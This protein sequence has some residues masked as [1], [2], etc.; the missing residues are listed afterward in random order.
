ME[1]TGQE[2]QEQEK[3][4][5]N[6]TPLQQSAAFSMPLP[7]STLLHYA[8]EARGGTGDSRNGMASLI[9]NPTPISTPAPASALGCGARSN[10]TTATATAALLPAT[11]TD[12]ALRYRQC[13]RNHA[14]SLGG[15]ILDGCCEFMPRSDDAL[16]CAACGCHRSFHRRDTDINSSLRDLQNGTHGRVPLLL[17][18]PHLSLPDHNLKLFGSAG[19]LLHTGASVGAATESSTEELMLGAV[20]QQ[21]F[22]VSKKRFRTKFTAE[23]K[24]MMMAF[25]EKVGWRMQKQHE[26]A[27]EQFCGEVGVSRQVLK[28]WMHNNKNSLRKQQQQEEEEDEEEEEEQHHHHQEEMPEA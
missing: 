25:A 11:D 28:V 6:P 8:T 26:A 9:H 23:Q 21:R 15:H 5:Y 19:V 17:P 4:I 20:P 12:A 1:V 16:K 18:P 2:L 3:K 13:L 7:S 14:A 24:E 27:V 22:T 10:S